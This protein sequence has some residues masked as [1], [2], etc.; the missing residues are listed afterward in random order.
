MMLNGIAFVTRHTEMIVAVA[1]LFTSFVAVWQTRQDLKLQRTH[2]AKSFLPI[3][4]FIRLNYEDRIGVE[5]R[6]CGVGP[7]I[8]ESFTAAQREIPTARYQS[9]VDAMPDLDDGI[10]WTTWKR[11]LDRTTLRPGER[12]Q[13]ILLKGDSHDEH[14]G[15][16]RNRVLEALAGLDL[17]L[18]YRDVYDNVFSDEESLSS[19]TG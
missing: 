16:N 8:I 11:D 2:H 19:F 1:A 14:F 9:I 17:S 13:L 4:R 6:N 5:L 10:M 12:L 18:R 3:P 7:L 15:R